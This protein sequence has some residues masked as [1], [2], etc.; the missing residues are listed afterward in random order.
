MAEIVVPAGHVLVYGYVD[1]ANIAFE[2]YGGTYL[3][4]VQKYIDII[5]NLGNGAQLADA[6]FG[7]WVGER[8]VIQDGRH[9]RIAYLVLGYRE[10]LVRWLEPVA[11][12]PV[13]QSYPCPPLLVVFPD[14]L[15]EV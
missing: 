7:R 11:A 15:V 2:H 6:P 10:V 3:P 8:F 1:D 12:I 9:R 4:A 14:A 5:A 13:I